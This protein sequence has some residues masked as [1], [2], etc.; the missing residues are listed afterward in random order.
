MTK[1]RLLVVIAT[2]NRPERLSQVLFA[3]SQG[4]VQPNLV[5]VCDSSDSDVRLDVGR[6]LAESPVRT[7]LLFS[8]RRS[9]TYQ[10]N[11]AIRHGRA[12]IVCD[13]VQVL[14]D[15]TEPASTFLSEQL[16]W[17]I[18]HKSTVGVSGVTEPR[19][20]RIATG[21]PRL[22]RLRQWI[23]L[24]SPSEGCVTSAG[25]NQPIDH[26]TLLPTPVSWLIGCSMWRS[27]V[28]DSYEYR[29]EFPGS[30]L[31]EDV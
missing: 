19:W 24:D 5:V 2:R 20:H 30:G 16:N 15:D 9:L 18:R 21:Q 4:D 23:G 28:F 14:D 31:G 29:N 1:P 12:M 7:Q 11:L 13:F 10:R 26:A 3:L 8:D 27:I 6:V 22:A 25:V 17:L